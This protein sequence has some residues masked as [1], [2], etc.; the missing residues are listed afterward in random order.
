MALFDGDRIAALAALLVRE[1]LDALPAD[2]HIP[3]VRLVELLPLL[4][5]MDE[6]SLHLKAFTAN[7]GKEQLMHKIQAMP[8]RSV[9]LCLLGGEIANCTLPLRCQL[10]RADGKR[11]GHIARTPAR[12]MA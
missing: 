3:T 8:V 11:Q 1:L 2:E 6:S 5:L 12:H 9:H 4:R 10:S 7:L